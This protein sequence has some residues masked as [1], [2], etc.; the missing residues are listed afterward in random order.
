MLRV[1]RPY[2]G[3]IKQHRRKA[4]R[5]RNNT[6]AVNPWILEPLPEQEQPKTAEFTTNSMCPLLYSGWQKSKT[7]KYMYADPSLVVSQQIWNG[8]Q[9]FSLLLVI[10]VNFKFTIEARESSRNIADASTTTFS[11]IS[12]LGCYHI[13]S[14]TILPLFL[15]IVRP[16]GFPFVM[17]GALGAFGFLTWTMRDGSGRVDDQSSY[18]GLQPRLIHFWTILS[19]TVSSPTFR[20]WS[21]RFLSLATL[22]LLP[23]SSYVSSPGGHVFSFLTAAWITVGMVSPKLNL[24]LSLGETKQFVDRHANHGF[25]HPV[26]IFF[27]ETLGFV[28]TL[29]S[30]V[31]NFAGHTYGM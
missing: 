12:S 5:Q 28:C 10:V 15:F 6:A 24:R 23:F 2:L 30:S 14:L 3:Y 18:V 8:M 26:T 13:L 16:V 17:V 7:S 4:T 20:M 11:T 31:Y 9:V 25:S 27:E 21:V 29:G 19:Q 22:C 1:L